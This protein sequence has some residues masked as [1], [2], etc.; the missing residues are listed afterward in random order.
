MSGWTH[1]AMKND[2][3]GANAPRPIAP[4]MADSASAGM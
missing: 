2:V 1:V 3:D 4:T